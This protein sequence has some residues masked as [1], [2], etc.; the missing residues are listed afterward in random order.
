MSFHDA[1]ARALFAPQEATDPAVLQLTAQ[2]AFAVYRNTVMKGC[3][4]ALEANFPA[5]ARL[6]GSEWFR[7]A[8]A[9][10]VAAQPP[11]DGQLLN[12]GE[13]FADFLKRFEPAAELVYLPGVAQLDALWREAH[14]AADAPVLDAAWLA[15]RAPEALAALVLH[16][17]PAARWA[18]FA[19]HPIYSIWARNRNSANPDEAELI[20]QGEG[21]L[22]TRPADTVHWRAI[23]EAGCAFLDACASGLSLGEA[24]ER[25]LTIDADADLAVLLEALLR[26]GAFTT[27]DHP[28]ESTP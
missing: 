6:V 9:L 16:P 23:D 18:W 28:I 5:V 25:A 19:E 26:A 10:H 12:Y 3:I 27:T 21:A 13:G 4:D 1:F 2:P 8:A 14:A 7:A 17:H 22:L 11:R 24:A 15:R 20:W